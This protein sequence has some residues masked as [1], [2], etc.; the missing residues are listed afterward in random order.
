MGRRP[1]C[2][3]G[4]APMP[5][6][7]EPFGADERPA[8]GA[9]S[10]NHTSF[11]AGEPGANSCPPGAVAVAELECRGLPKEFTGTLHDPFI[12]NLADDPKGCFKFENGYYFNKHPTGS[13]RSMRTPYCKRTSGT[14]VG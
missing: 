11:V 4:S 2:K 12:E 5:R 3:L 6:V 13:P 7:G 1:Y 10:G 8:A 14:V 9:G